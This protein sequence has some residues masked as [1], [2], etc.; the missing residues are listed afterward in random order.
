MPTDQVVTAKT[1]LQVQLELQRRGSR[2]VYS[3]LESTERDLAEVV[4]EQTTAIYHEILNTGASSKEARRI[5]H[6]VETLVLVSILAL[7]KAHAALWE[8]GTGRQLTA[9]LN[10]PHGTES[11]TVP[12]SDAPPT[13]S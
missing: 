7:Q 6:Q 13:E 10:P 3:V 4:L 5:H 9:R 12:A 8:D 11:G 2:R 1:I